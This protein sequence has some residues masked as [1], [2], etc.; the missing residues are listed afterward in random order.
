MDE[1]KSQPQ[2]MQIESM[3]TETPNIQSKKQLKC[4]VI[5]RSDR[6][7]NMRSPIP[8]PNQDVGPVIEEIESDQEDEPCAQMERGSPS[9]ILGEKTLEEKVDQFLQRLEE[10]E[11]TI[12]T[13]KSEV[14]DSHLIVIF[15]LSIVSGLNTLSMKYTIHQSR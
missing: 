9:S 11:K 4:V 14:F 2:N 1:T 6:L 13:L 15:M 10:H 3:Q 5:R 12:E 8:T 7:Q